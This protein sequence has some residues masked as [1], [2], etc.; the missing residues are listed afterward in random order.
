MAQTILSVDDEPHMLKLLE[1]IITEKTPFKITTTSNSLEVPELLKQNTYDVILADLKMPGLDGMDILR[2][3]RE[4][5]RFEEVIIIT[6]FGSLETAIESLS[7]GVFDYI[8]KPFKKEQIIF[9]IKRAMRWQEMKRKS[10]QADKMFAIEPYS[11]A[12]EVFEREYVRR[13][14]ERCEGN[15]EAMADRSGLASDRIAS[16]ESDTE[17]DAN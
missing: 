10:S 2:M 15:K 9:T 17:T 12:Q 8:T 11:K 4:Q 1:R 5:E 6:A 16:L 3:V 14:S 7:L 13:L